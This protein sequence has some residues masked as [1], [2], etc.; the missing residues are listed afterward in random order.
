MNATRLPLAAGLALLVSACSLT[1]AMTPPALPIPAH[2]AQAEALDP[3]GAK[4]VDATWWRRFGSA[5]LDQLMADALATNHDLAAAVARI[6][7]SRA[8][9]RAARAALL[10][11]VSASGSASA[12]LRDGDSGDEASGASLSA[13]Y[14]LDLWGRNAATAA[15]AQARLDASRYSRDAVALVLQGDVASNFFQILALKDR[16]ALTEENRAAAAELLRLVQL[17]FDNGA[18]N[19]LELAQQKTALLN[20]EATLPALR[21]SLE[22]SHH[23]LAVL[24]ARAPGGFT[25]ATASL[26]GI[27][28]PAIAVDAPASLLLQRPDI[29]ASESQLI[30]ANAD[31]GVARAALL[32]SLSLSASAGLDGL[33][34][35]GSSSLLSLA[36][37]LT[38]PIFNSGRLQSQ[39]KLAEAQ[40][41]ELV[42]NY[43]Q[44]VLLAL[45]DVE[46]NL[47]A[48][49][50]NERR[51]TLLTQSTEQAR[52]AYQLART[53]YDAGADDLLTL[54]DAQRTRLNAEDSLVQAGLARQTAAIGLFKA[55]GGGY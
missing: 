25:V 32:P 50:S 16:L 28:A 37:S 52:L 26:A 1:P 22:Q 9:A 11:T 43:A 51:A 54:L 39:V 45:K 34:T 38:Q 3:T 2:Y 42:E 7:Q 18:A 49:G 14:E 31:I 6:E 8:N 29:R 17:R 5:E 30:A 41:Q 4:T 55:L 36:A 53:R 35:S 20:I 27:V 40:R 47:V 24:L 12:S 48:V 13:A 15:S 19:A 10:P 46:D 21:L 33:I 23:A 44:T